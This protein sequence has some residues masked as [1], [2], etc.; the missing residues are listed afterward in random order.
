MSY[1]FETLS[2]YERKEALFTLCQKFIKDNR[3]SCEEAVY[4]TDKVIENAYGF[5]EQVCNL[6]GYQPEED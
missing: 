3:I 2:L 6:V 5:I 4:Q 1:Q